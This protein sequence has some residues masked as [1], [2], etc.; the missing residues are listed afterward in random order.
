M[1]GLS[2]RGR[3]SISSATDSQTPCE[4]D[5]VLPL[6]SA[7]RILVRRGGAGWGLTPRCLSATPSRG[8]AVARRL[9]SGIIHVNDQPVS[10]QPKMPF[11][12]V[13]DS[14]WKSSVSG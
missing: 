14:G 8:L 1:L 6:P 10:D 13:K 9:Q 12:G 7:A 3:S 2:T 5:R 4:C 11:G